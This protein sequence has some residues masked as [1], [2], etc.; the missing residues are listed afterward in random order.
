[1]VVPFLEGLDCK[2]YLAA[3][4]A[5][6]EYLRAHG[7]DSRQVLV[8]K[9]PPAHPLDLD[10]EEAFSTEGAGN[11]LRAAWWHHVIESGLEAMPNVDASSSDANEWRYVGYGDDDTD[12][13]DQNSDDLPKSEG[14]Y[15]PLE[16]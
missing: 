16:E 13:G 3:I 4:E 1:M 11:Q 14:F 10:L 12:N 15:D 7:P 9:V 2:D 6:R 5:A 8:S